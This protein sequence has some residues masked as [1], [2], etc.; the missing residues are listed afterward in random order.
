MSP[1]IA[2]ETYR[3]LV[4]DDT[5]SIH[6]DL[7]KILAPPQNPRGEVQDLASAIFGAA[8]PVRRRPTFRR[9]DLR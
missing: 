1:G 4:I 3:V 2:S 5:P 7:R 8:S 9:R 6:E